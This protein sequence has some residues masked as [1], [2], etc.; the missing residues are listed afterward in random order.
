MTD[1]REEY[2]RIVR[3]EW[4]HADTVAAWPALAPQIVVQQV[5]M[6]DALLAQSALQPGFARARSRLRH[7]RSRARDRSPR[8][9][10]AAASLPPT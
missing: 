1:D 10:P 7:R 8:R 4:T 6:R 3:D 5:N 9:A 2:R